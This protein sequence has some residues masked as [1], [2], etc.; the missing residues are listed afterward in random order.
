MDKNEYE[1]EARLIAIE[2]MLAHVYNVAGRLAGA[3]EGLI[4]QIE[5]S[6]I[7]AASLMPVRNAA[8]EISDHLGS[9][10]RGHIER[11]FQVA[12]DQR[13]AANRER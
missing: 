9:M 3:N 6:V 2:T 10:I 13:G 4:K 7:E 11:I 12:R 5:D 8:P 1:L